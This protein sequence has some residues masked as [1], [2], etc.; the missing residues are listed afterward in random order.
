DEAAPPSGGGAR[1]AARH[2]GS[3]Q[4][5]DAIG[6]PGGARAARSGPVTRRRNFDPYGLL[7]FCDD[8]LACPASYPGV[9]V[10][11]VPPVLLSLPSQCSCA[12]SYEGSTHGTATP[13]SVTSA[14]CPPLVR[15]L[16]RGERRTCRGSLDRVRRGQCRRALQRRE[17]RRRSRGGENLGSPRRDG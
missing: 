12:S 15:G 8:S 6:A 3:P 7:R 16:G 4:E 14:R 10:A 17:P 1:T 11:P 5:A 9:G 2:P 13:F